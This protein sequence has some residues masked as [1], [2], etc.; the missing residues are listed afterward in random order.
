MELPKAEVANESW[1]LDYRGRS[2]ILEGRGQD[3]GRGCERW[4]V[5]W[6]DAP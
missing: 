5:G 2:P 3:R 1:C 6:M 4:K